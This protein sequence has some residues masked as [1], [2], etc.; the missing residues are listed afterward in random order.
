MNLKML[1]LLAQLPMHIHSVIHKCM[2]NY[3]FHFHIKQD[4]KYWD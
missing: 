2:G 4:I 3:A 1:K